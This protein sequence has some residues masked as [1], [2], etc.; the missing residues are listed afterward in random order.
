MSESEKEESILRALDRVRKI[1]EHLPLAI[2]VHQFPE[3]RLR[4]MSEVGLQRL[5][6]TWEE[7]EHLPYEQ[8]ME[9]YFNPDHF[10]ETTEKITALLSS[11]DDNYFASYFQQVR[12]SPTGDFDWYLST[13][14]VFLRNADGSP[15]LIIT[16]AMMIDREDPF[17][18]KAQRLLEEITFIR[19]NYSLFVKLGAREKEILGLMVLGKNSGEIADEL[20]ISRA[21][22]ET[23]RRNIRR[24]LKTTSNYELLMYARAFDLT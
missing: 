1:S 19:R 23:H 7:I 2:I 10:A 13:S 15:L 14:R 3:L 24:K 20:F 11:T 17:I 4:F 6:T 9:R 16:T 8:F 21:T 18:T 12:T 22:V 5:R